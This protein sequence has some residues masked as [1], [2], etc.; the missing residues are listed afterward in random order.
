ML[1]YALLQQRNVEQIVDIPVP[2]G[3]C[4]RLQDS[5]P[6]Q[7]STAS[8]AEQIADSPFAKRRRERRLRSWWRHEAQG[9][10]AAVVSALHH[11][12]DVGPAKYEALRGQK[13][14]AE[15]EE[16]GLVTHSGLRAPKP[17]PP[18]MRPEPLAEPLHW[19]IP[20]LEALCPDDRG[21]PSLSLPV[22]A[23]RAADGVDSSSLHILTASALKAR[24]KEEEK[25]QER[26]DKALEVHLAKWGLKPVPKGSPSFFGPVVKR[27]RKNRK[28][29]KLPKSS[30]G[31][32]PRAW[33]PGHYSSSSLVPVCHSS[34]SGLPEKYR[35]IA[36]LWETTSSIF[37]RSP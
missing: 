21:A 22:L 35:K 31:R 32:S 3:R 17:L 37:P 14:T 25:E 6:R 23:D 7:G 33:K 11:S 28:K 16:A 8:G 18:G 2:H 4:C 24:R 9:V 27:K 1:S 20:G 5:L 30:S 15:V 10:Q 34:V 12:R 26:K 29:H 19:F 13:K 36:G